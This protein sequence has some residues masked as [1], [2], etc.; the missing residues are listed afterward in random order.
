MRYTLHHYRSLLFPQPHQAKVIRFVLEENEVLENESQN[1]NPGQ[2]GSM[3]PINKQNTITKQFSFPWEN[4]FFFW[5]SQEQKDSFL[6]MIGPR[7]WS[8]KWLVQSRRT[9]TWNS[10]KP[11]TGMLCLI[12]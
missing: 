12:R 5:E 8:K 3:L 2:S 4:P 10:A 1:S 11:R 9:L 7:E 6:P